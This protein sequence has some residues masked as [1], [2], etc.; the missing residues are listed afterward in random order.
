ML[1]QHGR[2]YFQPL[3]SLVRDSRALRK[4]HRLKPRPHDGI[5]QMNFLSGSIALSE[6]FQA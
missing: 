4:T 3:S 2:R 1:E 5:G 6:A